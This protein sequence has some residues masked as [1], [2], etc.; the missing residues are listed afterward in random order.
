[1]SF[2]LLP[3]TTTNRVFPNT[4][5]VTSN[6]ITTPYNI[7]ESDNHRTFANQEQQQLLQT[8]LHV[9]DEEEFDISPPPSYAE[10]MGLINSPPKYETMTRD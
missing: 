3:S 8:I 9:T 1:M 4:Q 6:T 2:G 10:S 7:N 5:E